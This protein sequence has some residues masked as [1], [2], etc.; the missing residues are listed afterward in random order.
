[1]NKIKK[2]AI[3]AWILLQATVIAYLW[4][5]LGVCAFFPD[6]NINDYIQWEWWILFFT[7]D[8]WTYKFFGK[9]NIGTDKMPTN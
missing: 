3:Y 9:Q 7:L 8:L 6:A 1:M 4:T 5:V 2:Y